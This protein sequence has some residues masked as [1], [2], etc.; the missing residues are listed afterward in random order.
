VI[1]SNCHM[2]LPM[3][4]AIAAV[5]LADSCCWEA[6]HCSEAPLCCQDL[7][8][9]VLL[10][11]LIF[12]VMPL[13]KLSRRRWTESSPQGPCYRHYLMKDKGT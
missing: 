10:V 3:Y 7:R 13:N 8:I 12:A 2:S 9:K 11:P 5:S 4:T 6:T 1:K